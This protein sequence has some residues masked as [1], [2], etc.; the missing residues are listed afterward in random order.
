MRGRVVFPR[1]QDLGP[2][3]VSVLCICNLYRTEPLC[4]FLDSNEIFAHRPTCE[5]LGIKSD[6][7][8]TSGGVLSASHVNADLMTTRQFAAHGSKLQQGCEIR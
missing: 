7:G 3:N 8:T 1:L 2:C 6:V 4:R 5:D